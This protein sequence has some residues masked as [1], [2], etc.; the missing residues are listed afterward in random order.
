MQRWFLPKHGGDALLDNLFRAAEN[1]SAGAT[2]TAAT[3][4]D[5]FC[6]ATRKCD[7]LK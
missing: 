2:Q 3:A 7:I 4:A 1:S 5:E 6:D